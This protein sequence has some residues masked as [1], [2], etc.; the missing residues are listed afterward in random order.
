M[1]QRKKYDLILAVLIVAFILVAGLLIWVLVRPSFM[2]APDAWDR[3]QANRRLVVGT[4]ADYPPFEYYND[5]FVLDGFDI[6]LMHEVGQRLNV[7]VEFRDMTFSGLADALALEQIDAAI[8]AISITEQR[9]QSVYFSNPYF[10]GEDAL[11]AQSEAQVPEITAVPLIAPYQIGVQQG[12]VYQQKVQTELVD[13]GLMPAERVNVYQDAATALAD[14]RVGVVQLVWLDLQPAET[15]VTAGDLKIVGQ[16]LARQHLAVAMKNGEDR[17][18]NEINAAITELQNQGRIAQLAL[19]YMGIPPSQIIPPQPPAVTST[20]V[21]TATPAGCIDGMR[22]IDDINLDDNNM[23]SPPQLPPGQSFRKGWRIENSGTCT[24]DSRYY[25]GYISGNVPAAQMGGQ[26]VAINTAVPPGGQY[27]IWVDLVA[28]LAPDTYQG[29]WAMHNGINQQF[30]DRVWVGITI[31][32]PA[33]ATP[34]PTQTPSPNINFSV[35]RS[36]ISA[37]ECVLFNWQ[38]QGSVTAVYLNA[39]GQPL[40][41]VPPQGSRSECPP[42]TTIYDLRADWQNGTSEVRQ[43]AI[44][45]QPVVGAPVIERFTLYPPTEI[46]VGQCVD[47]TWQVS[48]NVSQIAISR[49]DTI[50]NGNAPISGSMQNCPSLAGPVVY[51]LSATGPGGSSRLQRSLNVILPLTQPPPATAPPEVIPPQVDS[52]DVRPEE[53]SPGGCV[54]VSWS[55]SGEATHIQ[56]KRDGAVVFD[57]ASYHGLVQDCPLTSGGETINYRIEAS[58]L[59]SDFAFQDA[60]VNV[61]L[62][63]EPDRPLVGTQWVLTNYWDGAGAVIAA[64]PAVEVTAVFGSDQFVSGSTGCNT[65]QAGYTLF[66]NDGTLA[67][68]EPVTSNVFCADPPGIMTQE[69]LVLTNLPLA[70]AY[71]IS[72]RKLELKD[73]EGRVILRYEAH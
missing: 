22:F 56:I 40:S 37:G 15:A 18:R 8:S 31:S 17:L 32:S 69:Q 70:V 24:W 68:G 62:P 3:I 14:L 4:A 46:L 47:L 48:G 34:M 45:V 9:S 35:D 30:G 52:F 39:Q 53:I 38:V 61:S 12:S 66:S 49:D 41:P 7:Q 59:A 21:A 25:L 55:I 58:N 26:P 16:G 6:A 10:I 43:I 29:F 11:L 64:N 71:D 1:E 51:S 28:P 19:D 57:R 33:T 2:P 20:P 44:T 60:F 5:D 72:G 13:T 67:I 63:S 50:I 42:V 65:Y 27:D 73:N 36:Q 23:A 54:N